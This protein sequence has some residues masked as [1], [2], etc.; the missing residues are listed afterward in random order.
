M[1]EVE[2]GVAPG[3]GHDLGMEADLTTLTELYLL[4]RERYDELEKTMRHFETADPYFLGYARGMAHGY[5][6]ATD[7]VATVMESL[8]Q[9]LCQLKH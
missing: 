8:A 9:R 1:V 7:H 2:E 6:V 4:L 5:S 3:T